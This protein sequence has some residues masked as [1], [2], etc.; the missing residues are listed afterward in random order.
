M[1]KPALGKLLLTPWPVT[2]VGWWRRQS[3]GSRA[4]RYALLIS[5]YIGLF[6][7]ALPLVLWFIINNRFQLVVAYR[8]STFWGV[9]LLTTLALLATLVSGAKWLQRWQ[10][11]SVLGR[12]SRVIARLVLIAAL[13]VL[14]TFILLVQIGSFFL[15]LSLVLILLGVSG[16]LLKRPSVKKVWQVW[17]RVALGVLT[18][19]IILA[20]SAYFAT[21]AE[22]PWEQEGPLYAI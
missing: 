8:T 14:L 1:A 22:R 7:I 10:P 18:I 19:A 6:V 9:V 3:S 11:Q 13:L 12:L 17:L 21:L 16:Y 15:R 2:L 5:G 4:R 20:A